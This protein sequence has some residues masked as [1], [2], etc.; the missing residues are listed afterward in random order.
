MGKREGGYMPQDNYSN[1]ILQKVVSLAGE[2]KA[3]IVN[4]VGEK[5]S[6]ANDEVTLEMVINAIAEEF[7][8]MLLVVAEENFIRGYELGVNDGST[9]IK[10]S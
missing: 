8:E 5:V 7:P 9:P 3:L 1:D 2:L 6:P 10:E 4:Y